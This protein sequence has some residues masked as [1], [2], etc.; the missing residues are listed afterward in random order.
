MQLGNV[1]APLHRAQ[2]RPGA[3]QPAPAR[4]QDAALAL[5]DELLALVLLPESLLLLLS[6]ELVSAFLLLSVLLLSL[7]AFAPEALEPSDSLLLLV[8]A[9]PYP[10]AY[11]PPPFSKNPVP[12]EIRRLALGFPHETHSFNGAS[13]IRCSAS[14]V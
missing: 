5:F 8:E 2:W 14:Q 13:L 10:S 3:R 12:P 7:E 11:Q 1:A 9:L 6:L 4:A